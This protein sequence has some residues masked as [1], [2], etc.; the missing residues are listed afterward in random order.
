MKPPLL[1]PPPS[2]HIF[3]TPWEVELIIC[4]FTDLW[5]LDPFHLKPYGSKETNAFRSIA[6]L[7]G[8]IQ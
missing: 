7:N 1:L 6:L 4:V 8:H 2:S 3:V 5:Q